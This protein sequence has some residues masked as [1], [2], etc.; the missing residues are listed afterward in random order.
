MPG[1]FTQPT[2]VYVLAANT[3]ALDFAF[4][5][6]I[7]IIPS[8]IYLESQ[9]G[10]GVYS[11]N[12]LNQ[13]LI[14]SGTI[15]ANSSIGVELDGPTASVTNMISGLIFGNSSG[16]LLLGSSSQIVNNFGHI[17]EDLSR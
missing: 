5:D 12:K 15:L 3:A 11:N 14:N 9:N 13:T 16:I 2:S 7:A 6:E 4:D 1:T 17:I 10:V 8:E